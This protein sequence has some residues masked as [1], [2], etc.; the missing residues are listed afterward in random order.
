MVFSATIKTLIIGFGEEQRVITRGT[1]AIDLLIVIGLL[2]WGV[3][4]L[5]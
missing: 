4:V 5:F 3:A 2:A 1:D